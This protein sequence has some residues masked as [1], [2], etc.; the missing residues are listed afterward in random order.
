M[1][2]TPFVDFGYGWNNKEQP[3]IQDSNTLLGIGLGLLWQMGDN[4]S[5]RI[6]YGIPLI[7]VDSSDRTLQEKGI[8]FSL[9]YSPF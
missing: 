3:E 9:R 4:F 1:Q 7:D 6:D 8:Y 5:A 2:V